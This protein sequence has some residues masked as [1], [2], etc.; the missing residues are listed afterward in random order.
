L[1]VIGPKRAEHCDERENIGRYTYSCTGETVPR[2][3]YDT[4]RLSI[5]KEVASYDSLVAPKYPHPEAMAENYIRMGTRG[6]IVVG[7]EHSAKL[8]ADPKN[9]EI[10]AADQGKSG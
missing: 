1:C 3:T 8:R 9:L 4:Q 7:I 2:H 10:V 6:P 5:E